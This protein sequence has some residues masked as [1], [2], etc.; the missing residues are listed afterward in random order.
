MARTDLQTDVLVAGGGL[1]GM[2]AAAAMADLGHDVLCVDFATPV[3]EEAAPGADLRS[4]ALLQPARDLLEALGIWVRLQTE[5]APLQVMRLVDAGGPQAAPRL[6]RNFDAAEIGDLPFG[7]NL[8]NWLIRREMAAH[9]E[10]HPRIRHLT[11]TGVATM[12]TRLREARLRLT[13]GR[14]VAA[15]LVIGADGRAS[16]VRQ[17]AGIAV[18]TLR[19]GQKALAF[20]VSHPIPH[21]NVSTEI[22]RTGGPFTLVPLPDRQAG[23]APPRPASAVVW[24][25]R[26]AE[27]QRLLALDVPEFEA[28]MSERSGHVLGPLTLVSQRTIWPIVSQIAASFHAERTA[29]VA[30]AAHVMPPIGAQGLNTS[31]A[32]IAALHALLSGAPDPG[33]PNLLALYTRQRRPEV[34]ARVV[35]IDALNRAAMAEAQPLRDA[36]RLGLQ[37]LHGAAPV[38]RQLMKLGLGATEA[39]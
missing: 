23:E 27:A 19:Y 32:D 20:A 15:R 35:G 16:T 10:A 26:A 3:T 25:E 2:A 12:A 11:G 31:L 13:D 7:W 30:E 17:A 9:L 38:R 6:T 39:V 34:L 29:L 4:T 33:D 1:A 24:M 22:H 5:A 37:A 14:T 21:Q 18:R 28:A 8:P 36:R